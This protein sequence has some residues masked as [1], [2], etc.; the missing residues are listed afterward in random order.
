MPTVSHTHLTM[1]SASAT[2]VTSVLHPAY[3]QYPHAWYLL[4]WIPSRTTYNR[5][6]VDIRQT[7]VA[8]RYLPFAEICSM[9]SDLCAFRRLFPGIRYEVDVLSRFAPTA[10]YQQK[11]VLSMTSD[12]DRCEI[13]LNPIFATKTTVY[14]KIWHIKNLSYLICLLF[15]L[16][17]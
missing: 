10:R 14:I 2:Y 4:A 15:D 12:N 13:P 11:A 17:A 3:Y 6:K 9:V 16:L 8:S 7:E 5:Y 1:W